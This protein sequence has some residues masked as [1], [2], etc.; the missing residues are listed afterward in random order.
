MK[1]KKVL[2]L[3]MAGLIMALACGCGLKENSNSDSAENEKEQVISFWKSSDAT[4]GWY[5]EKISEFN[6]ENAGKYKVEMEVVA[7]SGTFSYDD[8]VSAAVTSKTLPDVMMVDGPYVSTY[9]ENGLIIPIEEYI[10]SEDKEDLMPGALMQNTYN[11]KL[12]AYSITESSVAL[13]YNIDMLKAAGIEMRIPENPQDALT[14][15]EYEEIAKALTKDGVVGTNIILDKGEGMIYALLP[16]YTTAGAELI[17]EDGSV[18]SGYFNSEASY[19][20]T[21]FLNNLIQNGY[22]NV[23]PIE[24]EFANQKA[25]TMISGSYQLANADNW[26]F[27]WGVTYYPIKEAGATAASP[28]GDWV[29]TVTSSSKN[30]EAAAEFIS[31][32]CSVENSTENARVNS[33]IPARSSVMEASEEWGAYPNSIFKEQLLETSYA[34]PRTPVYATLTS[35]FSNGLFDIFSGADIQKTLDEAAATIDKEYATVYGK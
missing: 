3:V 20:A 31:F 14:W 4:D 8:K 13:Y 16:F 32:I 17:S 2:Y 28:C 21:E 27:D 7:S 25:A 18:A 33:K 12:Y 15:A 29:F 1:K 24:N 34:R 11:G 10:S 19:D 35:E 9:A 30:P 5:E 26:E 23:D 6:K 22:A